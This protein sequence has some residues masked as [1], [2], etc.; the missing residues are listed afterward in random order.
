[1]NGSVIKGRRVKAGLTQNKLATKLGVDRST[2]AKWETGEI[3]PRASLLPALA[4][5]LKCR[6]EALY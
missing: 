3:N 6:I 4:K 2:V 1:M 5:A